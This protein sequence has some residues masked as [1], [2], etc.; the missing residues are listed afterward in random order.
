MDADLV[1]RLERRDLPFAGRTLAPTQM[2]PLGQLRA[3]LRAIGAHLRGEETLRTSLDRHEVDG[4]GCAPREVGWAW[5]DELLASDDDLF[6]ARSG[7]PL[8]SVAIWPE[9]ASFYL[10]CGI[11]DED[12]DPDYPGRWGDFDV[13]AGEPLLAV[14]AAELERMGIEIESRDALTYFRQRAAEW[15]PSQ[16]EVG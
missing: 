6:A 12:E 1:R 13:S 8:V 7:E 11:M 9:S 14:V 16:Q 5:V 15:P 4:V 10:R 2:L 3:V